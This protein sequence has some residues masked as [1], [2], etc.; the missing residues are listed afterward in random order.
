MDDILGAYDIATEFPTAWNESER[1]DA[2]FAGT[3]KNMLINQLMTSLNTQGGPNVNDEIDPLGNGRETVMETL[4]RR[5]INVESMSTKEREKYLPSSTKF[6][7][8]AFLL[9]AH[10]DMSYSQLEQAMGYLRQKLRQKPG[11]N[12][13]QK[14]IDL[15]YDRFV[16][17]KHEL[18]E[19]LRTIIGTEGDS[20]H[21]QAL[22]AQLDETLQRY[23]LMTRPLEECTFIR[24][25]YQTALDL[26]KSH[27][28]VLGLAAILQFHIKNNEHH[29]FVRDWKAG[30]DN[31]DELRASSNSPEC[32]RIVKIIEQKASEIVENYRSSIWKQLMH[33]S[34][35]NFY[36]KYIEMLSDLEVKQ[37]PLYEWLDH[38]SMQIHGGFDDF[39]DRATQKINTI[40][41]CE[42]QQVGDF[43]I[44][45]YVRRLHGQVN[46]GKQQD[47]KLD[48]LD[49]HDVIE[50]WISLTQLFSSLHELIC[51]AMGFRR[52]CVALITE[53]KTL[54]SL[55]LTSAQK[56]EINDRFTTTT[57]LISTALLEYLHTAVD[58]TT[59][60]SFLKYAFLPRNANSLS[61]ARFLNKI[62]SILRDIDQ[63]LSMA[64]FTDT[65]KKVQNTFVEI[66]CDSW[67]RDSSHLGKLQDFSTASERKNNVA[68]YYTIYHTWM[69]EQL[70]NVDPATRT[71][72]VT[73]LNKV[74]GASLTSLYDNLR[75]NEAGATINKSIEEL[76]PKPI[77]Q[78]IRI[79]V[80][81]SN[82][83]E[84]KVNGNTRIYSHFARLFPGSGHTENDQNTAKID[85]ICD[86]LFDLYIRNKRSQ[87]GKAVT[88]GM[89]LY[90]T[91][92]P[93]PGETPREV[94]NYVYEALIM[95]VDVH[96]KFDTYCPLMLTQA[97]SVLY[98][99]F[100]TTF[101]TGVRDTD[102]LNTETA[103]QLLADIE[104][105]RV[106]MQNLNNRKV[107]EKI[108]LIYAS[109]RDSTTGKVEW[110]SDRPPV[111]LINPVLQKAKHEKERSFLCFASLRI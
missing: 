12:Q 63:E 97:V 68:R 46:E 4:R 69:L 32:R 54:G 25:Q 59:S 104:Y 20:M 9:D 43:E 70:H 48:E 111:K 13:S 55:R 81:M 90:S 11:Y 98:E 91:V 35:D 58:S 38:Q 1:P 52:E 41:K 34:V 51:K 79:L 19:I 82:L 71:D 75:E 108:E 33:A 24:D 44:L 110:Q 101:L 45:R 31:L 83:T 57:R 2:E 105:A 6:N 17:A 50:H 86:R 42:Q 62:L 29:D 73:K 107:L 78:E 80:T 3:S 61:T 93:K 96:A 67:L 21:V 100:L 39:F 28:Y 49:S 14:S 72:L 16:T 85:E 8:R 10:G 27:K 30:R 103:L 87:I 64:V 84:I 74:I 36:A 106:V 56:Q 92:S 94:S 76:S 95:M 47:Q 15:D 5:G 26:V 23:T 60:T 109:L 89:K 53:R 37:N 65:V 102:N 88:D 99:H 77:E 40:Y 66:I 22:K 7:P 18:D